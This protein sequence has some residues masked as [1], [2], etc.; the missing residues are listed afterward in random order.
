MKKT[1]F[2]E[3][4]NLDYSAIII[5]LKKLNLYLLIKSN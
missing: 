4:K 1:T 3:Y 5:L 2:E